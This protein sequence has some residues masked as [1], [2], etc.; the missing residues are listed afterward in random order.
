MTEI[1]N[2]GDKFASHP[3]KHKALDL[4]YLESFLLLENIQQKTK[5]NWKACGKYRIIPQ[6]SSAHC[7][8]TCSLASI[9]KKANM[10]W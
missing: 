10:G 4:G 8:L 6:P 5:Y 2:P 9:Y 1:I 7:R 3:N